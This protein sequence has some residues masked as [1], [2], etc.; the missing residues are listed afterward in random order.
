MKQEVVLKSF[1]SL[2]DSPKFT[3]MLIYSVV[4]HLC[5]LAASFFVPVLTNGPKNIQTVYSVD[6]VEWNPS[7]S[8]GLGKSK[9]GKTAGGGEGTPNL[10]KTNHIQEKPAVAPPAKQQTEKAAEK[11]PET[12]P[13]EKPVKAEKAPVENQPMPSEKKTKAESERVVPTPVTKPTPVEKPSPD[14]KAPQPSP[15]PAEKA[16]VKETIPDPNASGKQKNIPAKPDTVEAKKSEKV[17]PAPGKEAV[18]TSTTKPTPQSTQAQ[19][20]RGG[21]STSGPLAKN[22]P[23]QAAPGLANIDRGKGGG[24]GPG[25]PGTGGSGNQAGP[26]GQGLIASDNPSFQNFNYLDVVASKMYRNWNFNLWNSNPGQYKNLEVTISIVINRD[27]TIGNPVVEKSS[28]IPLLDRS[29]LSAVLN[30]N[31]LPP[32]PGEF[33]GNYLNIH[34]KFVPITQEG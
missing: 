33:K 29:A 23:N 25:L 17:L 27:G 19:V 3:R 20:G 7:S 13:V 10:G 24:I 16:P 30:S 6:L 34:L 9:E 21:L 8:L 4:F 26:S 11:L 31:P 14:K 28:G 32:L 1:L 12:P 22:L 15:K 18:G 2:D 5:I